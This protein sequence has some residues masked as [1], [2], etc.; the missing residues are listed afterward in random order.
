MAEQV[1]HCPLRSATHI[2]VT[3]DVYIYDDDLLAH[4]S[5]VLRKGRFLLICI[6]AQHG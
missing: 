4:G 6:K 1:L 3:I 5:R 2:M